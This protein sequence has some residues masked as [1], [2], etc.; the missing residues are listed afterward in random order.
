MHITMGEIPET[1]SQYVPLSKSDVQ[2]L[3][4]AINRGEALGSWQVQDRDLHFSVFRVLMFLTTLESRELLI[5]GVVHLVGTNPTTTHQI[6]GTPVYN[7]A[8]FLNQA[9]YQKLIEA[10]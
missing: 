8:R 2:K 9:D 3:A 5:D 10:L 6:N 1:D 7:A 4:S